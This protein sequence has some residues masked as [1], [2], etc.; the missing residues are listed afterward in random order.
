VDARRRNTHRIG[1]RR[2]MTEPFLGSLALRS[3]RMTEHAL[4]TR[5]HAVHRNVFLANGIPLTAQRRAKAA[6][7]F[8][9]P[10]AI[11][12]GLSA[13]AVHRTRWL[14]D[15]A[16][17]EIIR[18]NR[19][20]PPGIVVHTFAVGRDEICTR[21]GMRVTTP[22]RTAFDLGRLLAEDTATPILDALLH[23]TGVKPADVL[24]LATTWPRARG[25]RQLR[26]IL[27]FVDGGAESPKETE[28]R[29]LLVRAGL[30]KP[31]TQIKF[32]DEYGDVIIRLDMG[33]REWKVAVEY[34]GIQ[35]WSDARQRAWD[36]ER[37]AHLEAAG[38]IVVRVS[39][40]ML[41]RP[42]QL[43]ERVRAKLR[44]RGCPL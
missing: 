19:H 7:L 24:A 22:E 14:D 20:S 25:L 15:E 44:E 38:W 43:I 11:L 28:V 5:H 40:D 9:G 23:A 33:W 2:A 42:A 39:A 3:G 6:W 41:R 8:A 21:Q 4:R 27:E 18:D 26:R 36:I 16:P 1:D 32:Y 30:P 29:L 35:H 10:D 17:A 37:L 34:D 13:A 12:A 31:E